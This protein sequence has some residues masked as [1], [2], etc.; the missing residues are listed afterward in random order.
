M[1]QA[2]AEGGREGFADALPRGQAVGRF[3]GALSRRPVVLLALLLALLLA[4]PL[5]RSAGALPR[6]P[7]A[8]MARLLAAP[9][10]PA[11]GLLLA[12]PLLLA[13]RAAPTLDFQMKVPILRAPR[14]TAARQVARQS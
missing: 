1:L 4:A 3:A 13:L 11:M 14:E 5:V 7:V 2:A 9:L 12:L 6:H 10:L 8:R